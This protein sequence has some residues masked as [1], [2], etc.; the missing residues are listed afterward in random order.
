MRPAE[1]PQPPSHPPLQD[2]MSSFPECAVPAVSTRQAASAPHQNNLQ[3][4]PLY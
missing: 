4:H 3:S 2:N 1:L